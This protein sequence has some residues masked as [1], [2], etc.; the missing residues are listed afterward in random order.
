MLPFYIALIGLLILL[1]LVPS[2]SKENIF[3]PEQIH[4]T[5]HPDPTK[6][7][8]SWVSFESLPFSSM[9]QYGPARDQ[10]SQTNRA[11]RSLSYVNENE[12]CLTNSTRSVHTVDFVVNEGET[13]YYR[14]SGDNGLTF[15]DVLS[16]TGQSRAF[17]Q[18]VALWG[19][20]GINCQLP[21][22][23]RII[24]DALAQRH[25]Y[26]L[27]YGDTGY[28]MDDNCGKTGDDFL[29]A[30]QAYSSY[31]PVV[32]TSGNHE[33]GPLKRYHEY[34]YR[35]A[36][37]QNEL[38]KAS[39]SFNNRYFSFAVGPVAYIVIDPDAWI[40]PPVYYL[41]KPQYEW[42]Q[43]IL[44][45]IDRTETPWLVMLSHR[46]LYCTK[47]VDREC[48]QEAEILRN[49]LYPVTPN[50]NEFG[51]EELLLKYS[52]DFVFSGHVSFLCRAYMQIS[53]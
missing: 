13:V 40:Y 35:L 52:V 9:V 28:N 4:L 53:F 29:N 14:V 2:Y 17:P 39:Q 38:A 1:A 24:E 43:T 42:L 46:A 23:P 26:A 33:S 6:L 47:S 27:H 44:P 15:S 37:G 31:L 41:M 18:S 12:A 50:H 25:L 34:I 48:N 19:D 7:V 51:L 16:T 8:V 5:F 20:M 10:L 11:G 49:G 21:A 30:A 22:V 3:Q 45:T 36:D 32:Y